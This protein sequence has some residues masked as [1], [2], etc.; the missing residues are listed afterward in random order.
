MPHHATPRHST[1]LHS[2][3]LHAMPYH[4][5]HRH[6]TGTAPHVRVAKTHAGAEA[7]GGNA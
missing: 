2:T 6:R 1:P 4:T 7:E 5:P 3:P